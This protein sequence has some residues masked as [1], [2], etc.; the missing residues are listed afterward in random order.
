MK[1]NNL[2][3]LGRE[4]L[5]SS[6]FMREFLHSEISQ[7]SGIANIPHHPDIAIKNGRQLCQKILEPLQDNFGRLFI[8]SGYRSPEINTLGAENRNQ[9]KCAS[10]KRNLAKHIWDYP[11]KNEL[12]G[13]MACVVIPSY[14]E[15]Y[16]KSRDWKSLAKWI[17]CNIEE[18]SDMTFYPLLCAFNISWHQQ[19]N[20]KINSYI[21]K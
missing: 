7:I 18:Y 19:P 21:R 3:K 8:R 4:Q 5:S 14:L 6:F 20:R 12:Y 16:E 13:A 15:Y 9:Y 11:D 10:N 2:E 17:H 1:F